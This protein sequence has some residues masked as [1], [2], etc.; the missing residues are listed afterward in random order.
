[1]KNFNTNKYQNKQI[2]NIN[3]S[4]IANFIAN[5]NEQYEAYMNT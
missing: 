3:K 4:S 2:Q 1:M 5:E